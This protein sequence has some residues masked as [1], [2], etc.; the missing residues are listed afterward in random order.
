MQPLT[1]RF[2]LRAV[3]GFC[4]DVFCAA[5]A[6]RSR[7][8]CPIASQ[9]RSAVP[10]KKAAR[11]AGIFLARKPIPTANITNRPYKYASIEFRYTSFGSE[12]IDPSNL[13][14]RPPDQL[15]FAL[16]FLTLKR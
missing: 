2:C 8:Q 15:F 3:L 4:W 11:I 14:R 6:A 5:S 16:S 7:R 10:S 1:N 13:P 12:E 9:M